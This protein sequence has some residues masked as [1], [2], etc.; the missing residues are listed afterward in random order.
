VPEG[1]PVPEQL[2]ADHPFL[3][4]FEYQACPDFVLNNQRRRKAARSLCATLNVL[5]DS[6]ISLG[7]HFT[8]QSWVLDFT[9]ME[10][11]TSRWQ[12]LGYY[13][14]GVGGDRDSYTPTDGIA[15]LPAI[16]HQTYYTKPRAS[17]EGLAIPDNLSNVLGLIRDLDPPARSSFERSAT[18]YSMSARIWQGSRSAAY[19]ALVTALE[20][21]IPTSTERC[22]CCGQPKHSLGRRFEKFL[23]DYVPGIHT[24]HPSEERLLRDV[25]YGIRSDLAHG[26]LLLESDARPEVFA[27][28]Q[29][30]AQ[31][32]LQRQLFHVVQV[33]IY[34]WLV[35]HSVAENPL[36]RS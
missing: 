36:P 10:N 23:R 4:E 35:S 16:D 33:A 13:A 9:D 15:P 34:N 22:A 12:Q 17:R 26:S 8:E 14:K 32:S 27:S 24:K 1:S 21:L 2:V 31:S 25:H 30:M 3:L 18:W 7:S 11:V 29:Q 28:S 19:I 5:L 6:N 20:V